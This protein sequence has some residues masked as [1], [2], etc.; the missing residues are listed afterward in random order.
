L[1]MS[2]GSISQVPYLATLSPES[3]DQPRIHPFETFCPSMD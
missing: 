3:E 1:I 2:S